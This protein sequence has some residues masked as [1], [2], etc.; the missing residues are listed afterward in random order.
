MRGPCRTVRGYLPPR[1]GSW[2]GTSPRQ[3]RCAS[4]CAAICKEH[5]P[6]PLLRAVQAAV[7]VLRV[8]T[9][10]H[11]QLCKAALA[12]GRLPRI[13]SVLGPSHSAAPV[14]PLS[15]RRPRPPLPRRARPRAPA[16]GDTAPTWPRPAAPGTRCGA[17]QPSRTA[18]TVVH[19]RHAPS[20]GPAARQPCANP[21][22]HAARVSPRH[23]CTPSAAQRVP[24]AAPRP[25]RPHAPDSFPHSSQG[26][27]A[28][29]HH[30]GRHVQRVVAQLHVGRLASARAALLSLRQC[31]QRSLALRTPRLRMA[32]GGPGERGTSQPALLF[33][34]AWPRP[35]AT[36]VARSCA[37]R[38]TGWWPSRAAP[39]AAA[40]QPLVQ[41]RAQQRQ[42]RQPA[43]RRVQRAAQGALGRCRM[44]LRQL[45]PAPRSHPTH[46]PQRPAHKPAHQL[47]AGLHAVL[48]NRSKQPGQGSPAA[49]RP[50][51]PHTG[52]RVW[53]PARLATRRQARRPAGWRAARRPSCPPGLGATGRGKPWRGAVQR[54][55]RLRV[56]S[57]RQS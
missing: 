26:A 27:P 25:R 10:G 21:A 1:A 30:L 4:A 8:R 3:A 18:A 6:A 34:W 39:C 12:S 36:Y 7:Q 23:C 31:R 15:R 28:P 9:I 46:A 49:R 38:V 52:A 22:R 54:P 20:P 13:A 2:R 47:G 45:L 35:R 44:P 37:P 19:S 5:S 16:L 32:R 51:A 43:R 50:C 24:S 55:R 53:P 33:P 57:R 17:A 42:A 14:T 48:P 11:R 41:Q 40:H 29:Q 56:F